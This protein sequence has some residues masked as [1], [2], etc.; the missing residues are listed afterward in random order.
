MIVPL[1]LKCIRVRNLTFLHKQK[2][3]KG[4]TNRAVIFFVC[5]FASEVII[6][7]DWAIEMFELVRAGLILFIHLFFNFLSLFLFV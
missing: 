5:Y 1:L 6:S 3:K 2:L 4:K 7:E